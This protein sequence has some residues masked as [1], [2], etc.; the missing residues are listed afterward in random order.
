MKLRALPL[1]AMISL[2][3]LPPMASAQSADGTV[4]RHCRTASACRAE[5]DRLLSQAARDVTSSVAREQ[6]LF[7]WFGR[8]NMAST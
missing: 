8:I 3:G 7:Y 4:A 5:T 6:D 1:V 2:A